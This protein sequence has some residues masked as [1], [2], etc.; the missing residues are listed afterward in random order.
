MCHRKCPHL[1]RTHI[2]T[3]QSRE[4]E[5]NRGEG[6]EGENGNLGAWEPGMGRGIEKGRRVTKICISVL[7]DPK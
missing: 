3:E 7:Q 2:R 1:L 4:G 6:K 5:E